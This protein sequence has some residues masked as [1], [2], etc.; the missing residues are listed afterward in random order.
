M[1]LVA[2]RVS[3]GV[4]RGCHVAQPKYIPAFIKKQAE[5][6]ADIVTGTRYAQGGGVAGWDFR[7]KLTSRGAN[8]L[9]A[10]LLQPG[11]PK[12]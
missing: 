7:R 6:D 9:A 11:V 10:T 4:L 2:E 5:T 1:S 8:F 3:H 12:P